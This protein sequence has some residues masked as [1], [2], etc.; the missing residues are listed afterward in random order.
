[1]KMMQSQNILYLENKEKNNDK[2]HEQK[3]NNDT[4]DDDDGDDIKNGEVRED[5]ER[6]YESCLNVTRLMLLDYEDFIHIFPEETNWSIDCKLFIEKYYYWFY[7]VSAGSKNDMESY[8]TL[9]SFKDAIKFDG[10]KE[11]SGIKTLNYIFFYNLLH[12]KYF[13]DIRNIKTQ[14]IYMQYYFNAKENPL[15]MQWFLAVIQ[16]IFTGALL[17]QIYLDYYEENVIDTLFDD[18]YFIRNLMFS[19]MILFLTSSKIL[20]SIKYFR[21][22]IKILH[23]YF[24]PHRI[25]VFLNWITNIVVAVLI[26]IFTFFI[27]LSSETIIDIVLNSTAVIFVVDLDDEA[28]EDQS[29]E[30][31]ETLANRTLKKIFLTDFKVDDP[32]FDN[33]IS[34]NLDNFELCDEFNKDLNKFWN[35]IKEK[36]NIANDV[37]TQSV[38]K[39]ILKL[40]ILPL[41]LLWMSLEVFIWY[42]WTCKHKSK[43]RVTHFSYQEDMDTNGILYHLGTNFGTEAWKNPMSY[44][45]KVNVTTNC[46]LAHNRMRLSDIVGRELVYCYLENYR[47]KKTKKPQIGSWF[48]IDFKEFQVKPTHYTLRH[49]LHDDYILRNWCFEGSNDGR[50]W[51]EIRKHD[52]DDDLTFK[53]VCASFTWKIHCRA[54]FRF[55]RIRMS[56]KNSSNSSHEEDCYEL[57]CSGFEIYGVIQPVSNT[58]KRCILSDV[59]DTKNDL[60]ELGNVVNKIKDAEIEMKLKCI[61]NSKYY[62]QYNE[63]YKTIKDRSGKFDVDGKEIDADVLKIELLLKLYEFEKAKKTFTKL[64]NTNENDGDVE[65]AEFIKTKMKLMNEKSKLYEKYASDKK[66][67]IDSYYKCQ[68]VLKQFINAFNISISDEKATENIEKEMIRHIEDAIKHDPNNKE[69]EYRLLQIQ[70]NNVLIRKTEKQIL[71]HRKMSTQ[72]EQT[73]DSFMNA[74][75]KKVTTLKHVIDEYRTTNKEIIREIYEN[76]NETSFYAFLYDDVKENELESNEKLIAVKNGIDMFNDLIEDY[77]KQ[78]DFYFMRGRCYLELNHLEHAMKDFSK[79]VQLDDS[80]N[81]IF[82]YYLGLAADKSRDEIKALRYYKMGWKAME[83][84]LTNHF[85]YSLQAKL[86]GSFY[87]YARVADNNRNFDTGS[88]LFI[89][90]QD[91]NIKWKSFV[92]CIYLTFGK[93]DYIVEQFK[94]FVSEETEDNKFPADVL[95]E[96]FDDFLLESV[97]FH[98]YVISKLQEWQKLA[99]YIDNVDYEKLNVFLFDFDSC[100][101]IWNIKDIFAAAIKHASNDSI[102]DKTNDMMIWLPAFYSRVWTAYFKSVQSKNKSMNEAIIDHFCLKI[103]DLTIFE[104]DRTKTRKK[105]KSMNPD[106]FPFE[107]NDEITAEEEECVKLALCG[108]N[109][110]DRR[111]KNLMKCIVYAKKKQIPLLQ[112]FYDAKYRLMIEMN[113]NNID[114]HIMREILFQQP[115]NQDTYGLD[116]CEEFYSQFGKICNS[117]NI[118]TKINDDIELYYKYII[119]FVKLLASETCKSYYP[120]QMDLFIVPHGY[121]DD[122]VLL[123]KHMKS[124]IKKDFLESHHVYFTSEND[125]NGNLDE[126]ISKMLK[127]LCFELENVSDNLIQNRRICFVIDRREKHATFYIYDPP[128]GCD[129]FMKYEL[130]EFYIGRSAKSIFQLSELKMQGILFTS[131]HLTL[132]NLKVYQYWNKNKDERI[133]GRFFIQ[134]VKNIWKNWFV[135]NEKNKLF[136]NEFDKMN[137]DMLEDAEFI[138]WYNERTK[139]FRNNDYSLIKLRHSRKQV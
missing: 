46:V 107:D 25:N 118:I 126:I 71:I 7:Q 11:M 128:K 79:T 16:I 131:F 23:Q 72:Q 24:Q 48:M 31:W 90:I 6:L 106:E 67:S 114:S 9:R 49:D 45:K 137:S 44:W 122:K 76:N 52:D 55:F 127:N 19:F 20:P 22:D 64:S 26:P 86:Y 56:G 132:E 21:D 103:K 84:Q 33:N 35:D 121:S 108:F 29:L 62:Q 77:P 38:G 85:M 18:G 17:Y 104:L 36:H 93:N 2:N 92:K 110:V 10:G 100:D 12:W 80:N 4:D 113:I 112:Y 59:S 136:L 65:Q 30:D 116:G 27:I 115:K 51:I 50:K 54:F 87:K 111:N 135:M 138:V 130:P 101:D 83:S 57:H 41:E 125:T 120:F 75:S 58:S 34:W 15:T 123:E 73:F 134:D 39:G 60:D 14:N 98:Q 89:D 3:Y 129:Q 28:V 66:S 99:K 5:A 97:Y 91:N 40:L 124:D 69:V 42:I 47:D 61:R 102:T 95:A 88:E 68:S 63:A 119:A 105:V 82:L 78:P 53:D 70:I 1:M 117:S 109:T 96:L 81:G 8:R 94:E 133:G 139:D 37:D 43:E 74:R 13:Y 32:Q